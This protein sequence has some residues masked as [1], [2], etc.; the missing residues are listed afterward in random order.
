MPVVTNNNLLRPS[1]RPNVGSGNKSI[2]RFW[3]I[4]GGSFGG[5]G[6]EISTSTRTRT[7]G[8]RPIILLEIT[9]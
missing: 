4:S 7:Q 2:A 1:S 6:S 3:W 9:Q 8:I 5:A